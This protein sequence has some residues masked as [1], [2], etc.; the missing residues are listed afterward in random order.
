[1]VK[2]L[3]TR[4]RENVRP[5]DYSCSTFGRSPRRAK[6][7]RGLTNHFTAYVM[8]AVQTRYYVILLWS[9]NTWSFTGN[10]IGIA[11]NTPP[12]IRLFARQSTNLARSLG[13]AAEKSTTASHRTC[14]LL[15]LMFITPRK[16]FV[17][18]FIHPYPLSHQAKR[19]LT[20]NTCRTPQKKPQ[21]GSIT[22]QAM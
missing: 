20:I 19:L 18:M 3:H 6:G 7:I 13:Q 9:S 17:I 1:M 14:R 21:A 11:R 5:S 2:P 22:T 16:L 15:V 8:T 4:A 10:N 12:F